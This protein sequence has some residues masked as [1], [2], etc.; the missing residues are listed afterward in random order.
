MALK[1]R[2]RS[3]LELVSHHPSQTDQ[4]SPKQPKRAGF[5]DDGDSDCD[6]TITV[7]AAV[8]GAAAKCAA[9]PTLLT[10]CHLQSQARDWADR[11][12]LSAGIQSTDSA[13]LN[14]EG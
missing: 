14:L 12:R 7:N 5:R 11:L 6:K 4:S 13:T 8:C 1:E 10:K 2:R 9:N 3:S